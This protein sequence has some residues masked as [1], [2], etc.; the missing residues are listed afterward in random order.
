MRLQQHGVKIHAPQGGF[1]LFPDFSN[2]KE[3]IN[4]KLGT[5]S[6]I[7]LCKILLEQTGVALLAGGYFNQS[8]EIFAA[9][10]AFVDFNGAEALDHLKKNPNADLNDAFIEKFAPN[11][12]EG[13]NKLCTWLDDLK[14]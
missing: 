7:E 5:N 9:R 11:V 8:D 14:K 2:Y 13:I 6:S 3:Q 10:L 1:Y 12:F 4:T